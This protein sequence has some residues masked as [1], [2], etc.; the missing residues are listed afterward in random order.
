MRVQR[1]GAAILAASV[2]GGCAYPV[3]TVEQGGASSGIY[4]KGAPVGAEALI[5]G[6][7]SGEASTYDGRKA[8]L[9][10]PYGT[11]RVVVK[12]GTAILI[13][14]VVYVGQGQRISI[15]VP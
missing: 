2:L 13:D 7:S 1:I 10:V 14:Q 9:T 11:H 12:A 4:F 5:D 15:K 6:A 8:I 3:S